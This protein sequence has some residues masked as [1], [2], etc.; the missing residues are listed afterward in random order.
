MISMIITMMLMMTI[1]PVLVEASSTLL[2]QMLRPDCLQCAWPSR[3]VNITHDTNYHQRRSFQNRHRLYH[4]LLVYLCTVPS[5]HSQHKKSNPHGSD[6]ESTTKL[7]S[8]WISSDTQ[9][10]IIKYHK[11]HCG[12]RDERSLVTLTVSQCT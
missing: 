8:E 10:C 3:R 7:L 1:K 2:I 4:L 11:H 12:H 5:T 9:S 6:P